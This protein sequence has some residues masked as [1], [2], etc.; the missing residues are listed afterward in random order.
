MFGDAGVRR[1]AEQN[2]E[3]CY[4]KRLLEAARFMW[5]DGIKEMMRGACAA[6]AKTLHLAAD[7][8]EGWG[9]GVNHGDIWIAEAAARLL[10]AAELDSSSPMDYD[11]AQQQQQDVEKQ[12]REAGQL[13]KKA[14]P[15][16]ANFGPKGH[17]WASEIN[18]ALAKYH[19][20]REGDNDMT[21][22]LDALR[23]RTVFWCAHVLGGAVPFPPK[24]R[25]RCQ[26]AAALRR[27]LPDHCE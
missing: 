26:D 5:M 6:A 11:A 3:G 2:L 27:R 20:L 8:N 13:L 21:G 23:K 25:P 1:L 9:W 19:E 17:P 4:Q 22:W 14:A 7:K 12:L 16:A 24:P 10:C 18:V 15:R